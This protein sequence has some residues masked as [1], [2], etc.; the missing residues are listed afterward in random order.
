MKNIRL[1]LKLICCILLIC[2]LSM[3]V[4][5]IYLEFALRRN[6]LHSL[7][8]PDTAEHMWHAR[9]LI[10]VPVVENIPAGKEAEHF[11][12]G[13]AYRDLLADGEIRVSIYRE[14]ME[15]IHNWPGEVEMLKKR[16]EISGVKLKLLTDAEALRRAFLE[17]EIVIFCGHS[18]LGQGLNVKSSLLNTNVLWRLKGSHIQDPLPKNYRLFGEADIRMENF[19][20]ISPAMFMHL[21]CRSRIYYLKALSDASAETAFLLTQYEWAPGENITRLMDLL[22][23]TL[24]KRQNISVLL[25]HWDRLYQ[26]EMLMGRSRQLRKYPRE[27]EMPDSIFILEDAT[28]QR[29]KNGNPSAPAVNPAA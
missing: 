15:K 21:G 20:E 23:Q 11:A 14:P 6:L 3:G 16:A 18:N 22:C 5:R 27:T 25:K 26:S 9:C 1:P 12:P 10:N 8:L 13:I 24:E 19:P 29:V 4:F 7:G 17:D 28:S 2:A